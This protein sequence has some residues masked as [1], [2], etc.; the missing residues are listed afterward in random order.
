MT[1]LF[2]RPS[3]E[4][5]LTALRPW[6]VRIATAD[7]ESTAGIQPDRLN[8]GL[9]L[10]AAVKEFEDRMRTGVDDDER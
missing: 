9:A 2:E 6:T 7:N 5:F 1:G 10:E 8:P 3:G 4:S